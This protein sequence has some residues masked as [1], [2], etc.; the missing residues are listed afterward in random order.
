MRAVKVIECNVRASRTVPFVSKT[1]NVN[2][3]ELATR[4]MLRQ[5]IFGDLR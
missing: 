1:L 5:A 4:V 3:I 2:F